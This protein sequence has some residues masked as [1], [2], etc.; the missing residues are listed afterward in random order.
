MPHAQP[1]PQEQPSNPISLEAGSAPEIATSTDQTMETADPVDQTHFYMQ[2]DDLDV[3]IFGGNQEDQ[4]PPF[5]MPFQP[6]TSLP[7]MTPT[8]TQQ[9][10]GTK[11]TSPS[12]TTSQTPQRRSWPWLKLLLTAGVLIT[13]LSIGTLLVF[14]RTTVAPTPIDITATSSPSHTQTP[15]H[16]STPTLTVK[17]TPTPP[18][19]PTPPVASTIPSGPQLEQLGWIK[20]NLSLGD[21]V[22]ALRTATTFTDREMSYD[23]RNIGTPTRH[24]GTLTGATFLLTDGGLD[25]FTQNDI[26][27]SNNALYNKIRDGQIIQQVIVAQPL[28]V[29][30]RAMT[31]QGAA[32]QFAWVTVSF[33]LVQSQRDPATGQRVER[34]E[35]DPATGQSRIYQMSV[36]LLRVAPER[37]GTNAPMGGTGW[38]VNT[39][40]LDTVALPNIA[41][42]PEL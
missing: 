18:L 1:D 37:Q 35:T 13:T 9:V 17:P 5:V 23:Y 36:I 24:G 39:Y 8:G 15:P 12:L 7:T 27:V 21:A 11:G 31:V 30:F 25:R 20:A 14:A 16:I 29:K 2:E 34:V 26:R 41:T 3:S 40:T 28:L 42:S 6:S 10:S 38:L 33:T 32:H 22:E 4:S 19:G